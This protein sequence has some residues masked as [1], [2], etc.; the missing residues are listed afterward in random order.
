[1]PSKLISKIHL[2]SV[3]LYFNGQN[4]FTAKNAN[5]FDPENFSGGADQALQRGASHS[6]YPTAKTYSF[7]INIGLK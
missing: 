3:R 1:M 7:G 5:L 2:G 4:L 6:P